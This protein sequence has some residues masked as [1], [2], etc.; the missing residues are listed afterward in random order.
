[1]RKHHQWSHSSAIDPIDVRFSTGAEI[2]FLRYRFSNVTRLL[3]KSVSQ[4]LA[5]TA[6]IV[7]SVLILVLIIVTFWIMTAEPASGSSVTNG[8]WSPTSTILLDRGR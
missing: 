1:M 4:L 5:L 2:S 6:T 3:R 8:S 7:G